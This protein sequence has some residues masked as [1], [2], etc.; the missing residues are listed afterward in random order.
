MATHSIRLRGSWEVA[1]AGG[2]TRY[3]RKFGRP[4]T[5]DPNERVWLVCDSVFGPAGVFVNGER[6]GT[7]EEPGR[8]FAAEITQL[9]NPRNEVVFDTT[10]AD[11]LGEVALEIRQSPGRPG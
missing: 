8:P 6:V 3:A 5:L 2:R 7:V 4:R 11:P 1:S 9:L 10:S